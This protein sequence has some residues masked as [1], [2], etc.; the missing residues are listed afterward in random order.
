MIL[1]DLIDTFEEVKKNVYLVMRGDKTPILIKFNDDNFFHLVGLHKTNINLFMPK[2]IKSKTKMY[3]YLKGHVDKFNNILLSEA[4]DNELLNNRITTFHNILDLLS[5]ER[6][7]LYDLCKKT[8]GSMYDGDFGI[9]KIYEDVNCLLGLKISVT[10]DDIIKCAPQS[11]MSS[12]KVNYLIKFKK[13]IYMEK[14]AAIPL[15]FY[16]KPKE[17]VSI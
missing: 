1:Q 2:G 8:D 7:S 15:A 3:K 9:L 17:L 11:W 5:G 12:N 10:E 4:N 14:I 13:P 6:T 16:N